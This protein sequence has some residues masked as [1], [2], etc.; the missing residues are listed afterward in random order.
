MSTE[1]ETRSQLYHDIGEFIFGFSQLEFTIRSILATALNLSEQQFDVV[2]APYD[3]RELCEVTCQIVQQKKT[4]I[5]G[6]HKRIRETFTACIRL[7]D[8]RV[9]VAHGTWTVSAGHHS[10]RHVARQK[11]TAANYFESSTSV[12]ALGAQAQRLMG[13]IITGFPNQVHD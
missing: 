8:E 10:A 13:M 11:L 4:D 5:D 1:E 6:L 3:F 7:N 9:R 2:T 12:A